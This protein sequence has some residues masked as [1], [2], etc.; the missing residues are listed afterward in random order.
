MPP[1]VTPTTGNAP[2]TNSG[3]PAQQAGQDVGEMITLSKVDYQARID[4]T[5][6]ERLERAKRK[7]DED[8]QKAKEL[9]EQEA[10]VKNQEWQKLAEKHQA[11]NAELERAL[12]DTEPTKVLAEKFEKSLKAHLETL[13]ANLPKH[14]L[15]LLDSRDPADQLEWISANREALE[16]PNPAKPPVVGAPPSPKPS[17][18]NALSSEEQERRREEATRFYQHMI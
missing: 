6:K 4:A 2:G 14:I 18:P 15:S 3:D 9:A 13:R 10:L 11:R 17:N 7:S 5:V 12:A 1:D 16:Q 8:V